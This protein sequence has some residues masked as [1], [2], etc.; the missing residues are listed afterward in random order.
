MGRGKGYY[1]NLL[2]V[3]GKKRRLFKL[4]VAFECQMFDEVPSD[5][6]DIKMDG[7]ITEEKFL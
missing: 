6:H 1:D 2:S 4:G 7:I 3:L 5:E